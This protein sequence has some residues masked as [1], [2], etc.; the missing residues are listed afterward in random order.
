MAGHTGIA[1]NE[2][3]D[4][5]AKKAAEGVTSCKSSLPPTT[6]KKDQEQ[7][8]SIKAAQ[9]GM[10]QDMLAAWMEDIATL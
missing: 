7:Q 10:T 5:E 9:K 4:E 1:G 3:V 6:K 2:E 8:I